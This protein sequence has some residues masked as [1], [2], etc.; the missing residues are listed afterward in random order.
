MLQVM[1]YSNKARNSIII[2]SLYCL[3]T[4]AFLSPE[5]ISGELFSGQLSDVYALG[6]T[7]FMLVYG[8]PPFVAKTILSLYDKIQN[9]PL[10]FPH[11]INPELQDLLAKMLIK[12]PEKRITLQQISNHPWIQK[13]P[14]N[15]P[16]DTLNKDN[17]PSPSLTS[18]IV[19]IS[20]NN[21]TNKEYITEDESID[22]L[23]SIAERVSNKV[24]ANSSVTMSTTTTID[25]NS[26]LLS[27]SSGNQCRFQPPSSYNSEEQEAMK[28]KIGNIDD[29]EVFQSIILGTQKHLSQK[30]DGNE[31]T[32]DSDEVNVIYEEDDE[33]I[34]HT[35]WGDDV[36]EIVEEAEIT[37]NNVFD[38]NDAID[39]Y[40]DDSDNDTVDSNID[41]V[42][43]NRKDIAF[44]SNM[45]YKKSDSKDSTLSSGTSFGRIS[46]TSDKTL[47]SS[48]GD[49]TPDT[50]PSSDKLPLVSI[51]AEV[52]S[53][54][55]QITGVNYLT[56]D[57]VTKLPNPQD[58]KDMKFPSLADQMTNTDDYKK[59]NL[60]K[61]EVTMINAPNKLMKT[62]N[63]I[64]TTT[65][66][67]SVTTTARPSTQSKVNLPSLFSQASENT[68]PT[69]TSLE[70]SDK[71]LLKQNQLPALGSSK[72]IMAQEEEERRSRRFQVQCNKKIS[73]KTIEHLD[74]SPRLLLSDNTVEVVNKMPF[75]DELVDDS[76][77]KSKHEGLIESESNSSDDSSKDSLLSTNSSLDS[78]AHVISSS[79][80][81]KRKLSLIRSRHESTDDMDLQTDE[82]SMDEFNTLMDTL[83]MQP[84][85]AYST[86]EAD[87]VDVSHNSLINKSTDSTDSKKSSKAS[88]KR[89]TPKNSNKNTSQLP[90]VS[91]SSKD[92][93]DSKDSKVS[94][95]SSIISPSSFF[96][97]DFKVP[98]FNSHNHIGC[99]MVSEQGK[100][101]SQEDRCVL[102]PDLAEYA[103][104]IAAMNSNSSPSRDLTPYT[105][106]LR[107]ISV[108]LLFDGHSGTTSA[109]YLSQNFAK[110]LIYHEKLLS[111]VN[112]ALLD[113]C[114]IVDKEVCKLSVFTL[115]ELR[116]P[117]KTSCVKY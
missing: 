30:S 87:E 16:N 105:D 31:N 63:I 39:N 10:V 22:K 97:Y 1:I 117:H 104:Q 84:K 20:S 32:N 99:A 28:V 40:S 88:N 50:T 75:N 78:G 93:K 89:K 107:Q 45:V 92:S 111:N 37:S 25:S 73:L 52:N 68:Q 115:F 72:Q 27:V 113:T 61:D 90:K 70:N 8:H 86:D 65:A 3:G 44:K 85:I 95:T 98:N 26:V 109:E 58:I 57:N 51:K 94:N 116:I 106:Q 47:K 18:T 6:A 74:H 67:S 59:L 53:N 33:N 7:I 80:K 9:E 2:V 46:T 19:G 83:A 79:T 14:L 24:F 55:S 23:S 5:Q 42:T 38:T 11:D 77:A 15:I 76:P 48:T 49:L 60:R 34:M 43:S 108:G 102:I 64:T 69:S 4:P 66:M 103:Q 81:S 110:R 36:F 56:T 100:R 41:E 71:G 82:L 29:N 112:E 54:K 21:Q 62:S 17:D 13:M 12:D 91:K 96:K 114:R 35:N 101:V